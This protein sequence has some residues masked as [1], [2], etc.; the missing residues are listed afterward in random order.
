M[1]S[2]PWNVSVLVLPAG[3]AAGIGEAIVIHWL[4]RRV[5]CDDN[6]NPVPPERHVLNNLRTFGIKWL[7]SKPESGVDC[8]ICA[9]FADR[10]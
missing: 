1:R 3:T 2:I 5:R 8:L 9:I 7:K 6:Q 4:Q 10:T